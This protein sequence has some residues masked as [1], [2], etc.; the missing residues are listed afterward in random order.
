MTR[1]NPFGM[2]VVALLLFLC[3]AGYLVYTGLTENTVYFL[4]VSE[5]LAA[6]AD[7]LGSVRL[8][9]TVAAADITSPAH[10][11]GVSFTLED[12]EGLE[13][14]ARILETSCLWD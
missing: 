1:K 4:N 7:R 11:L 14:F 8:F 3:G 5:A 9:G 10:G 6:P 13:A 12:K 2:Y